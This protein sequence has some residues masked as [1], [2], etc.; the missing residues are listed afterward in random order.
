[1][2]P[3]QAATP[4][5]PIDM[6]DTE[7]EKLADLALGAE[8]RAP[9]VSALLLDE[10]E[11][12]TLHSAETIPPEVVTMGSRVEFVDEGSGREHSVEL[13]YP[14]DADISAGRISI[15]TQVGAGLIGLRAGQS[16]LWPGRDGQER[17]LVIVRVARSAA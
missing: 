4:R 6:I 2:T 7:A 1:M 14:Q 12:A 8:E 15:L 9:Q 5:P 17:R 10:I 11:R 3:N 13:V 16:I